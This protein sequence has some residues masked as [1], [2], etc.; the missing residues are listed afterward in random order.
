MLDR[1]GSD[2]AEEAAGRWG[3]FNEAMNAE[4]GAGWWVPLGTEGVLVEFAAWEAA[5]QGL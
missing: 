2:Y 3:R 1:F 5:G 4:H